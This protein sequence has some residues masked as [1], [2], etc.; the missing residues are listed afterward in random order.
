MKFF[1]TGVKFLKTQSWSIFI[2][3]SV[4]KCQT[5]Y[6][7]FL[8]FF[9]TKVCACVPILVPKAF[10]YKIMNNVYIA[11]MII[12]FYQSNFIF[13][14]VVYTYATRH[15]MFVSGVMSQQTRQTSVCRTTP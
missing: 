12:K 2:P 6:I 10:C 13:I 14:Y 5:F 15:T 7:I 1:R 4:K 3:D 11:Y 8:W 9:F